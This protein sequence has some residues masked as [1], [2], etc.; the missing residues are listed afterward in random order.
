MAQG[1]ANGGTPGSG[2]PSLSLSH[3][4]VEALGALECFRAF[5]FNPLSRARVPWFRSLRRSAAVARVSGSASACY[6]G[7]FFFCGFLSGDQ[8]SAFSGFDGA[9]RKC[10]RRRLGRFV[11]TICRGDFF[12][13]DDLTVA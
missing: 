6:S 13:S 3:R 9:S 8:G 2:I 1:R 5:H 10:F 4:L 11:A 7:S 12:V